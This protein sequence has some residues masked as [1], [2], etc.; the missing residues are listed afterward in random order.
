M[1]FIPNLQPG[2]DPKSITD[3]TKDVTIYSIYGSYRESL[4]INVRDDKAP[5]AGHPALKDQR[6]RQAL[7]L[8][9]NRRGLVKDLLFDT[10]TVAD[11]LWADSPFEDK[12]VKFTEFDPAAAGKLLDEAGWVM[13]PNKVRV[14]KGVKDV[15][16]VRNCP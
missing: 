4:W 6:V 10:T 3:A 5:K 12:T 8:A 1:D 7:R 13:G 16:M 9:I 15:P 14:S 11:T 2:S